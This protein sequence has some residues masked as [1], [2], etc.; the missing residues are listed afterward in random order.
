M[1]DIIETLFNGLHQDIEYNK[2]YSKIYKIHKYWARKPW[3]IVENYIKN[4]SNPNDKVMDPFCGSGCTGLEAIINNRNFIGYDLNPIAILVSLGSLNYCVDVNKLSNDFNKIEEKCKD[5]ILNLYATDEKCE[6]CNSNLVFK[7]L[8]IGPKYSDNLEGALYCPTCGNRKSNKKRKLTTNEIKKMEQLNNLDIPYWYPDN[9]FPKKFYKDRFSYKGILK[10][11]DMYTK[12]NLYAAAML[13]DCIKSLNSEYEDLLMLAF[14]NTVLH[15]SK[16]KGE[17]VRPLGVNNYWVPDDFIE[18]NVWF[19]FMDRFNNLLNSKKELLKRIKNKDKLGDYKIIH[20]SALKINY[21]ESIDYVF[22]DPPYGDAIQYSELSFIWNS[23]LGKTFNTEEEV[24]IN[25]VQ[26]KKTEEFNALLFNALDNIYKALKKE[27]Y[28][29]LCF[30]NKDF[31]IWK[32]V[33]TYCKTLGFSLEDISI[34]DTFGSPYNKYWAKFSPKTDIY[35]TFKKTAAKDISRYF[36]RNLTLED[37]IKEILNFMYENNIELDSV[38][39]YDITISLIIWNLFYNQGI[40]DIK[41]F[42]IKSFSNIVD[43]I[44]Q[45]KQNQITEQLSLFN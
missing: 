22:T 14:T 35:I 7:Y 15:I 16:L 13:L 27:K 45:S 28:F 39:I 12:R 21:T 2:D 3:Y 6:Y 20:D 1:K 37:I 30:Q 33:V 4:Y 26:N 25:P 5:R 40:L 10:V 19:R 9:F 23:W 32:D 38:K 31:K 41:K 43:N 18:E 8:L 42:D 11:S 17:N 36:K 44:I 29:T 24:I 34:Y